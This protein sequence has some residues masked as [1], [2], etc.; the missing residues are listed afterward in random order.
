MDIQE[1]RRRA[2]QAIN[3]THILIHP[4]VLIGKLSRQTYEVVYSYLQDALVLSDRILST[5]SLLKNKLDRLEEL[6][7]FMLSDIELKDAIDL[8]ELLETQV[9]Q[10]KLCYSKL[11][12]K[13]HNYMDYRISMHFNESV[14]PS[15]RERGESTR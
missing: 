7:P 10:L 3:E 2:F 15:F 12:E 6:P 14:F 13:I 1:L 5:Y 8:L 4:P 9:Q 11:D